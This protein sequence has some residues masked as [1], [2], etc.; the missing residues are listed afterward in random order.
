M[1]FLTQLKLWAAG[2]L[3]VLVLVGLLLARV[4]L[5]GK[6]A[7][8]LDEMIRQKKQ[9]EKVDDQIQDAVDAGNDT[10]HDLRSDP[11]RL[12]DDDGFRRD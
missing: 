4:F 12:R 5:A 11:D 9:E 6:N 10:A 1:A 3:G 2:A 7:E 8:K